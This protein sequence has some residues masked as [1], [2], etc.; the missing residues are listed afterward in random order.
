MV[1]HVERGIPTRCVPQ[2]HYALECVS[3]SHVQPYLPVQLSPHS[4]IIRYYS[5]LQTGKVS[6]SACDARCHGSATSDIKFGEKDIKSL[7][8]QFSWKAEYIGCTNGLVLTGTSDRWS[9]I[10]F[11]S[12]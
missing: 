2:R 11:R 6:W 7:N 5:D 3:C 1:S 4:D 12:L 9:A 8:G 10:L